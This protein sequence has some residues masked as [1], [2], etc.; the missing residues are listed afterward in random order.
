MLPGPD[1]IYKC[2]HCENLLKRGSLTS[3]N[4]F[5]SKLYSD[6]KQV[7]P[8]LPDFPNLTKCNKCNNIFWLSDLEEIG[9]YHRRSRLFKDN[10]DIVD[11]DDMQDKWESADKVDFLN[12]E[13]L[14]KALNTARNIKEEKTIRIWIWWAFNDRIREGGDNMFVE[15]NDKE[16]WEENCRTLIKVLD[17]TDFSEKLMIADLYRNLGEFDNCI[18]I[19]DNLNQ[20]DINWLKDPVEY[21]ARKSISRVFAFQLFNL[22]KGKKKL[23]FFQVRGELRE[24]Q[25]DYQGALDDYEKAIFLNDSIPFL[26]LLKAGAYE[27]LGKSKMALE[28]FDK[29]LSFNPEYADAYI[30]RSLFFRRRKNSKEAKKDYDKA[31]SLEPRSF[32]ITTFSE[33]DIFRY[34]RFKNIIDEQHAKM[35]DMLFREGT[36]YVDVKFCPYKKADVDSSLFINGKNLPYFFFRR[37]RWKPIMNERFVKFEFILAKCISFI[38]ISLLGKPLKYID[39]DVLN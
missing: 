39:N 20:D 5:N 21:L 8:M 2:P 11:E 37:K 22:P 19:I 34:G 15:T 29:A 9:C 28:S 7:A 12:I 6:G 33:I 18:D 14:C 17:D 32:E 4:T 36:L 35:V 10:D 30:N 3:G 1:L 13:D 38:R 24:K 23:P 16:R 31:L 27:K 26:Y 25:G